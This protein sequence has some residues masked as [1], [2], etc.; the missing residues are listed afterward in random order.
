[1]GALGA[2][3]KSEFWGHAW[4][5]SMPLTLAATPPPTAAAPRPPARRLDPDG[6]MLAFADMMRKQIVMPAHLMDDNTHG[7][8]NGGRNLFQDYS[9]VAEAIG[10]ERWAPE[11]RVPLAAASDLFQ[12][13]SDAAEAIGGEVMSAL[14]RGIAAAAGPHAAGG[15]AACSGLP[16]RALPVAGG[17]L[18]VRPASPARPRLRLF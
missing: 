10:G 7:A 16:W 4:P 5:C 2:H 9:D 12:G 18:G 15:K 6:A 13:C 8:A 3:I 14:R 17:L 11:G 1:M